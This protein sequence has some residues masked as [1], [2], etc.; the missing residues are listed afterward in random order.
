MLPIGGIARF[1]GTVAVSQV[2]R[3]LRQSLGAADPGRKEMGPGQERLG[4][5]S[6]SRARRGPVRQSAE[7]RIAFSS[8]FA[9]PRPY[10][11]G[12]GV[13]SHSAGIVDG[14]TNNRLRLPPPTAR[15]AR[16]YPIT[17]TATNAAEQPYIVGRK[18]ARQTK[19]GFDM[20]LKK[21]CSVVIAR[22]RAVGRAR[23]TVVRMTRALRCLASSCGKRYPEAVTST[24]AHPNITPG[25]GTMRYRV[26]HSLREPQMFY[27]IP[28]FAAA[29][30][31]AVAAAGPAFAQSSSSGSDS[32]G[33]SSTSSDAG[34]KHDTINHDTMNHDNMAHG[35]DS[36]SMGHDNM[37]NSH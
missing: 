4:R 2:R 1:F 8:A 20:P 35:S 33:H 15:T 24:A 30:F 3:G 28:I 9:T 17:S 13:F 18:I 32:M 26:G 19:L 5:P 23:G 16:L 6:Q 27:R 7:D 21:C 36:G 12:V 11:Q 25:R 10:C 34:M 37:S 31:L 29:A 14:Q 22:V